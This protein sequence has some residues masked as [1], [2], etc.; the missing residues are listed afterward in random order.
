MGVF[1]KYFVCIILYQP[2]VRASA[3]SQGVD[4][5]YPPQNELRIQVLICTWLAPRKLF[6]K[7]FFIAFY[8]TPASTKIRIYMSTLSLKNNP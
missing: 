8:S 6:P 3:F 7:F 5:K 1:H 4:F 2:S